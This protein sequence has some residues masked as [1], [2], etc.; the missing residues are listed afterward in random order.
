MTR[1]Q[2]VRRRLH[3]YSD[4]VS[5]AIYDAVDNNDVKPSSSGSIPLDTSHRPGAGAARPGGERAV[6]GLHDGWRGRT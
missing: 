5:K 1:Q 3:I 4:T 6:V 2:P